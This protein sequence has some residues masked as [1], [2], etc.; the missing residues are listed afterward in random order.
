MKHHCKS[1]GKEIREYNVDNFK[2]YCSDCWYKQKDEQKILE[3]QDVSMHTCNVCDEQATVNCSRCGKFLCAAH[4]ITANHRFGENRY[5]CVECERKNIGRAF[6]I[7][8]SAVLLIGA[9]LLIDI[10]T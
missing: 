8:L 1:C 4:H 6:L 5:L 3:S 10:L 7:L 9:I 2:S